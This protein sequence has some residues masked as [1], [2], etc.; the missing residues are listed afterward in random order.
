MKLAPDTVAMLRRMDPAEI[1]VW[2]ALHGA[3]Y[4]GT[5]DD[6]GGDKAALIEA[7]KRTVLA[8]GHKARVA[9]G[10]PTFQKHEIDDSRRWLKANGF[11]ASLHG[12][13]I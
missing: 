5:V 4:Q 1:V 7:E 3:T 6:F 10:R 13:A 12:A 2:L 8:G 11:T 9:A